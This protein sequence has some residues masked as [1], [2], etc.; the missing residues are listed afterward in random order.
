MPLESDFEAYRVRIMWE[1]SYFVFTWITGLRNDW[2]MFKDLA[3]PTVPQDYP[4]PP[5]FLSTPASN[6]KTSFEWIHEYPTGQI[7]HNYEVE[8][9]LFGRTLHGE[10]RWPLWGI[11]FG[12]TWLARLEI[13]PSIY[14]DPAFFLH[15]ELFFT[16]MLESLGTNAKPVRIVSALEPVSRTLET[17]V[18]GVERPPPVAP[19]LWRQNYH[20]LLRG[21]PP[22]QI[23]SRLVQECWWRRMGCNK[24]APYPSNSVP[25]VCDVHR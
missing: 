2:K 18:V 9:G 21:H 14:C 15:P 11:Q 1:L 3:L 17:A 19:R 20:L 8:I 23:A 12:S 4:L 6:I 13:P 7:H 10:E 24:P 5:G 25:P 16:A 22:Q